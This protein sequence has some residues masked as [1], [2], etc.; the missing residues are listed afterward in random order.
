M[1]KVKTLLFE[2]KLAQVVNVFKDKHFLIIDK[3]FIKMIF[4]W[5]LTY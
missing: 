5:S 2:I 3:I 1:T 4:N